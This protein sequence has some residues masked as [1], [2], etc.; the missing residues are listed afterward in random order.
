M[1]KNCSRQALRCKIREAMNNFLEN[2]LFQTILTKKHFRTISNIWNIITIVSISLQ[3]TS[4][5]MWK[6]DLWKFVK[7]TLWNKFLKLT[8]RW[9]TILWLCH[10]ENSLKLHSTADIFMDQ[11]KNLFSYSYRHD[12]WKKNKLHYRSNVVLFQISI[13]STFGIQARWD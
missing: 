8:C 3:L 4:R 7:I 5:N 9:V 2:L 6:I 13:H 11:W 1:Y 12:C 10:F